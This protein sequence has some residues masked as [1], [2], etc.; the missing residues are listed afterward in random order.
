[1]F[2]T[3]SLVLLLVSTAL[4]AQPN[5]DVYLMDISSATDGLEIT[6]FKNVSQ[7]PGYDNQPSFAFGW[8]MYA[9]TVNG[10]TEIMRHEIKSNSTLQYNKSTL[11]GEYSPQLFPDGISFSAVRLD[12]T[13]LQRL[14]RYDSEGNSQNISGDLQVAYYAFYK[15]KALLSSVLS[16]NRLDLVLTDLKTAK[17]DTILEN[18]G[19]SI[20]KVPNTN[21]MSYT[22]VNEEGNHDVYLLDM[23]DGESY[24]VCQLPIGIQDYAWLDDSRIVLGSNAALYMY[25]TLDN[26]EWKKVAD[27]KSYDISNITRLAVN[28][29][30][31][32]LALA[33]DPKIVSPADIVQKH[34]VPYN[35]GDLDAF[36]NC[37][38]ED[39]LI[40]NFPNKVMTEGREEM[41]ESYRKFMQENTG[42]HVEV[43]KRMVLGNY[44]IDEEM[45]TVSGKSHRQVTI[46]EV[47][48]ET[49]SSMT[50]IHHWNTSED[51]EKVVQDQLDKYNARDID[52][53]M[54]TYTEDI[55]LYNYPFQLMATG[56]KAMRFNYDGF[57]KNTPDLH[58]KIEAR[59]V[60][61]N[62]VIDKELVTMNGSTFNAIAIYEVK[63]GKINKVTFIQ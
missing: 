44:V 60:I 50:F 6:N 5:T 8:L 28:Q 26:S 33:A 62:K 21:S 11:G 36:V 18:V 53:F 24:F 55:Q 57:F 19:R 54:G 2:R 61:G 45:A 16:D 7:G 31:T 34:I 30:G 52:A 59:I 27:L 63:D 32:K 22:A 3:F 14:Y 56:Q 4:L 58:A 51:P 35:N 43:I 1:M 49:I 38:A 9:G 42:L 37:F 39:I 12:T 41:K 23:S 40:R 10:Q 17:S 46:Y 15:D 13:G 25:D 48:N 47:N 29:D 20:H